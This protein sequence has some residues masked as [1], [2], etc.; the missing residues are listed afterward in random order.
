[1]PQ[2]VRVGDTVNLMTANGQAT[3]AEVDVVNDQDDLDVHYYNPV[4]VDVANATRA[5]SFPASAD[6]FWKFA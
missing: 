2:D 4:R 1:M 3:T 6:E 5:T